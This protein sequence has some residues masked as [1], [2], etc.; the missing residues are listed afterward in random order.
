MC[1]ER[2]TERGK[3]EWRKQRTAAAVL[4]RTF[5]ALSEVHF[6]HAIYHFKAQEVKN[7]TLQIVYELE[8]K[9]RRY[10][11]RK[12]TASSWRKNS[13]L[14]NLELQRAKLNPTLQNGNGIQP[15]SHREA[16][17][18]KVILQLANLELNVQKWIP[19]CEINLRDFRKSPCNVRNGIFVH[20]LF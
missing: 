17:L 12:T 7:S 6:L 5:G 1:K 2:T 16:Q 18:A 10:G 19:S 15:H 3:T 11:L 9:W 20:R 13:H 4:F 8:L 14:A